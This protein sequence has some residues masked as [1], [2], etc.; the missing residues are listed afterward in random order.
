MAH[1]R[2]QACE[3]KSLQVLKDVIQIRNHIS[4]LTICG[5]MTSFLCFQ[6]SSTRKY[7]KRL[8]I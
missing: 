5:T 6:N 4:H 7:H 2:A 3:C 8:C 1:P